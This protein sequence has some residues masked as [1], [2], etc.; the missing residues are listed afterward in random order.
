MAGPFFTADTHFGHAAAIRFCGRPW[1]SVEEMDEGLIANW[2]RVVGPKSDVHVVGDF[3]FHR[4]EQTRETLARLNGRIHL[5]IG[6]HDERWIKKIGDA[7]HSIQYLRR[8][9]HQKQSIVLCHYALR[10]WQNSH[11]GAWHLYGHS[12]G[13]LEED[14]RSLSFDCGVDAN[15]Y[16]PIS[17]EQVAERMRMKQSALIADLEECEDL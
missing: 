5:V 8:V 1:G 15:N 12:H 3:S 10:V 13:T 14:P 4:P 9:K 16:A 11:Y 7:F 17:F 6:N 2:N